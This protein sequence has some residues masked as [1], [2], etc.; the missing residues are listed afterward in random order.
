MVSWWPIMVYVQG[1]QNFGEHVRWKMWTLITHTETNWVRA[2]TN[3]LLVIDLSGYPAG[4]LVLWHITVRRY[5]FPD[6]EGSKGPTQYRT[7]CSK[8][9]IIRRI[10]CNGA[11]LMVWW[12]YAK[13]Q[14]GWSN[15]SHY[16]GGSHLC[17]TPS[18]R[19]AH[20]IGSLYRSHSLLNHSEFK[21]GLYPHFPPRKQKHP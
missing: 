20:Y 19:A 7:R 8:G 1:F 13:E 6:V 18:R 4:I 10:S 11:S 16:W 2:V 3:A 15:P 21:L 12:A 14:G 17:Q 5:L 9:S